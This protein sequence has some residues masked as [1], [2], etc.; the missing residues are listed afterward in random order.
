MSPK[1]LGSIQNLK[2]N[3]SPLPVLVAEKIRDVIID[4]HLEIGDK[5]PNEFE[6]AQKL[7]VGRGTVREAIKLLVARNVLEIRRG[8]GTFIADN[9]GMVDDPFGLAYM[10]DDV[11]LV[12]ELFEIRMRME[13][14]IAEIAARKAT[15]EDIEQLNKKACEVEDLILAGKDH[16]Y[17]DE[18]FHESIANCT[19]NRVLPKLIPVIMYS[20]HLF[21][22]MNQ[23]QKLKET[24]TTHRAIV[25]AI[26]AHDPQRAYDAM[27]EH[28]QMNRNSIPSLSDS[29]NPFQN[30]DP[31]HSFNPK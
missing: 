17:K 29:Q 30:N 21:A 26:A 19:K 25:D 5:L 16:L 27:T 7:N 20:I 10:E 11:K 15:E 18:E 28:L 12:R 2:N 3:D 9:T 22:E 24:I 8:T 14:W 13:P 4:E 23:H 6:L 1:I 31:F